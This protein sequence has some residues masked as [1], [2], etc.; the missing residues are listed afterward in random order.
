VIVKDAQTGKQI[1]EFTRENNLFSEMIN[2]YKLPYYDLTWSERKLLN[3]EPFITIDYFNDKE[4]QY[5]VNVYQLKE[6]NI[7]FLK[8]TETNEDVK[9][10][11]YL[12]S[13]SNSNNTYIFS[14]EKHNH[15][16]GV[17]Q[18]LQEI[19]RSVETD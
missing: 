14:L 13:P 18:G 5:T 19:I 11:S 15:L 4:I 9:E 8:N 12:Y 1:I 3:Y 17:N 16:V 10:Y 2:I 6:T 7:D